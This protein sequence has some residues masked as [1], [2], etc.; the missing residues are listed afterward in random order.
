MDWRLYSY[1]FEGLGSF[2][3]EFSGSLEKLGNKT[4]FCYMGKIRV[5]STC[6]VMSLSMVL[7]K[8]G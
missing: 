3:I 8:G 7:L 1:F 2:R 4:G 5:Y 6:R